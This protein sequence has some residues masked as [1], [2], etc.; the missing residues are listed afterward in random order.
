MRNLKSIILNI[1][2]LNNLIFNKFFYKI[3]KRYLYV[4]VQNKKQKQ[5]NDV[6]KVPL[7]F[8]HD[9]DLYSWH[10]EAPIKGSSFLDRGVISRMHLFQGAKVLD[11]CS[12]DGFYPYYFYSDLAE[13]VDCVDYS[14]DALQYAKENYSLPNLNYYRVNL[15]SDALP[16]N[17]YDVFIWNAGL[18]YFSKE[19]QANILKKIIHHSSNNMV[20]VGMVPKIVEKVLDIENVFSFPDEFVL[21]NRLQEFFND[22][23]IKVIIGQERTS[24]YFT[25]KTPKV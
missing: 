25:C 14:E 23:E 17:N 1:P 13:Y 11:L 21:Q 20:L 24:Y 12:G 7:F 18:D 15:K 9:I 3:A 22:V 19:D 16:K 6:E 8:E 5:W 4:F 10:Q 2:F